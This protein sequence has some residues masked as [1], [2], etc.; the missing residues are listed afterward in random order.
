MK[1]IPDYDEN[2]RR[3]SKKERDNAKS[4]AGAIAIFLIFTVYY[5]L[6]KDG[7]LKQRFRM[8]I[9]WILFFATLS[10]NPDNI[11]WETGLY[12]EELKV[13]KETYNTWFGIVG[14]T[15]IAFVIYSWNKRFKENN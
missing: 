1:I 11:G 12:G 15:W 8:F 4:T 7:S 2:G 13:L 6:W 5:E 10:L 9:S 14:L 3:L